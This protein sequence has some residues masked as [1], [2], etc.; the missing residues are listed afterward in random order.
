MRLLLC[1]SKENVRSDA[2]SYFA[3]LSLVSSMV[4]GSIIGTALRPLDVESFAPDKQTVAFASSRHDFNV[5][6]LS[7]AR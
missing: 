6:R 1:A 5:L 7:H 4:L 2:Q 3:S